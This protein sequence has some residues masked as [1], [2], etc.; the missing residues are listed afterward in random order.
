[1]S[2]FDPINL[3]GNDLHPDEI[4]AAIEASQVV[5]PPMLPL[6]D[7]A[8][9]IGEA[10]HKRHWILEDYIPAREVTLF[11]G[12]GG[13]GKSL[14]AQQLATCVS[15]SLPFLGIR[16]ART[17]SLYITAEDDEAELH[18]R[19]WNINRALGVSDLGRHRLYLSSLRGRLG[20]E[21][22]TFAGD[23]KLIPSET[24]KH[25][26]T[27]IE[28]T[29][30]LFVIL[31]NL[32]HLYAGSENDRG[33]VTK[34]VNLIYSLVRDY[35]A[36][37]VLIG[38]TPKSSKPGEAAHDYSGTTAWP[39]SVRSQMSIARIQDESAEELDADRRV[40]RLPKANYSRTG[41]E[42]EF[43]WHDGAFVTLDDLPADYA[44][45][46]TR[47]IKVN[48]ENEAFLNCVRTRA[49]QGEGRLVG[50]SPGPNYAPS[51]FEGMPEAKG[52]KRATLKRAMDRLFAIGKIESHTYRNQ[53]KARD[54]TVIREVAEASPNAFPNASRTLSPNPPE[55]QPEPPR[56][57]TV[58]IT[59]QSGAAPGSAAPD[60]DD[61]QGER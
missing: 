54:V 57:H 50:P 48:G 32:A 1:M 17:G 60:E 10:P 3:D 19:Q 21:L 36:S 34:F 40:L 28:E 56:T 55:P 23:G 26:Q 44:A 51:Q 33:Q 29:C 20:N 6:Y 16:T 12:R 59:Y 14:F 47:V 30:A 41:I 27:T 42:R 7:V 46:L 35:G 61:Q 13:A 31:D 53:A 9:A 2:E 24:F 22:C 18:R 8:S 58:G 38:H 37:V 49:A 43:T 11:T 25:L 5:K 52:L 4:V 45:E 15:G 39:N